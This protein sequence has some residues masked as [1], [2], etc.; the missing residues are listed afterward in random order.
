MTSVSNFSVIKKK[1]YLGRS[2][3]GTI[4][5]PVDS[6]G[7]DLAAMI[8]GYRHQSRKIYQQRERKHQAEWGKSLDRLDQPADL[9]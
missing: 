8:R 1:K 9:R 7:K 2:V 6:S 5:Q 3:I 4:V